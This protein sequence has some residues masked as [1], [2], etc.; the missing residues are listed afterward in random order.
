M[1]IT[2]DISKILKNVQ[3]DLTFIFDVLSESRIL[4]V[5]LLVFLAPENV[6]SFTQTRLYRKR[7][8]GTMRNY[9]ESFTPT[10]A[11]VWHKSF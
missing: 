10:L 9:V 1:Q 6:V 2:A 7:S 11:T 8:S 3:R 5:S 4:F